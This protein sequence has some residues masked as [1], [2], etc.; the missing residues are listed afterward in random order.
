MY[1][2]AIKI[3]LF[4]LSLSVI[5]FSFTA[6]KDE[7]DYKITVKGGLEDVVYNSIPTLDALEDEDVLRKTGYVID[8][9][10]LDENFT[11]IFD[12]SK[13]KTLNS[14]LTVYVKYK[15]KE[16]VIYLNANGGVF[17]ESQE[18][19]YRVNVKYGEN[20]SLPTP[21]K[22]GMDF[23]GYK[24]IQGSVFNMQG[25]YEIDGSSALNAQWINHQYTVKFFDAT[26]TENNELGEELKLEY[27]DKVLSLPSVEQG[28]EIEN[29]KVYSNKECSEEVDLSTFRV[30][31]D[32]SLYV[33][34]VPKTYKITV[35]EATGV[36]ITV[37][38]KGNYSLTEP[39]LE[40]F[41][42]E[43]FT[44]NGQ[45]FNK[46]GVYEF[47][48]DIAIT[49]TWEA[50]EGYND[51]YLTYYDGANQVGS[52]V[53]LKKGDIL[54]YSSLMIHNKEGYTFDGWYI[55][56][57]FNTLFTETVIT[58]NI[59]LYGKFTA[60]EYAISFN[61]DG[62]SD[63]SDYVAT[64]NK[65]YSLPIPTKNGY[66]FVKYQYNGE[67]FATSGT[68]TLSK[69]IVLKAVWEEYFEDGEKLAQA[70]PVLFTQRVNEQNSYYFKDKISD[71]DKYTY[72]FL[73]GA[74]YDFGAVKVSSTDATSLVEFNGES[75]FTVLNKAGTFTINFTL[76]N[77]QEY[78]RNAK[79]VEYVE[80]ISDSTIG[81]IQDNFRVDMLTTLDVGVNNFIPN[82]SIKSSNSGINLEYA[83]VNI[84]VKD[85]GG[86]VIENAFTLNGNS[87]TFNTQ[88]VNVGG[89]YTIELI[90]RYQIS[91]GNPISYSIK[92]NEGV[93]V[94]THQELRENFANLSVHEI[95]IL[96][97]IKAELAD[98]QYYDG[99]KENGPINEVISE[100]E[101]GV[102]YSRFAK[103]GDVLNLHGNNFSIDGSSLPYVNGYYNNSWVSP[104]VESNKVCNIH[105]YMFNYECG[106]N[107]FNNRYSNNGAFNVDNLAVFGNNVEASNILVK[108][109]EDDGYLKMSSSYNG[110]RIAGGVGTFDNISIKNTLIG[111]YSNGGV[112]EEGSTDFAT[113]ISLNNSIINNSW[114]NSMYLYNLNSLELN[115]TYIGNSG[116]AS[117]HFD[118]VAYDKNEGNAGDLISALKIDT[119][120]Q[121]DNWV[122]GEEAWFGAYGKQ[123]LAASVKTMLEAQLNPANFTCLNNES[124]FNFA[125]FTQSAGACDNDDWI[126]DKQG[127]PEFTTNLTPHP[128]LGGNG[129]KLNVVNET[130]VIPYIQF[131]YGERAAKIM[132]LL[133]I[134]PK[135]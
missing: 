102:P 53:K 40:G 58:E 125:V 79:V 60:N 75:V 107:T 37:K 71:S 4:L 98:N 6:C 42:F 45:P 65:D 103:S 133:P 129:I 94:Y 15:A 89:T 114:A 99:K 92:L 69:G 73:K 68:Y 108:K 48:H 1:K 82:V 35:N 12:L 25:K 106:E 50:I 61:T 62:G 41:T 31:D 120:T 115:N 55:D 111:L 121:I 74:K 28:Y 7:K 56:S 116:G 126:N 47:T 91:V 54:T 3:L 33:K 27:N 67:D 46:E 78:S 20:Y 16:Y 57:E 8:G 2:K 90:P 95:N 44:Y 49:A 113:K 10:Y 105:V 51:R 130:T 29:N 64:Y 128:T 22:S 17:S 97:T 39:T 118:E 13:N 123:P 96:R 87:L 23:N 18:E 24:T 112:S 135:A 84:S 19:T 36:D 26:K 63:L 134:M 66:K 11:E 127:G 38:Y 122:S 5:A 30:V 70:K 76:A 43:G 77:G 104:V 81:R 85:N 88:F 131:P 93:N 109:S 59:K 32:I 117:I 83:N 72:V 86:N 14:N 9:L 100:T 34:V 110:I 124:K 80:S 101:N 132:A 119:L 21:Q 52:Q